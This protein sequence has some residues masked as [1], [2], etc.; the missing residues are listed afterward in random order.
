M[1][2]MRCLL[3]CLVSLNV[4]AIG[5]AHAAALVGHWTFDEG[6]GAVAADSSPNGYDA[7]LFA[8]AGWASGVSSSALSLGPGSDYAQTVTNALINSLSEFSVAFWIKGPAIQTAAGGLFS[9][10]DKAHRSTEALPLYSGW[11]CQGM[12]ASSGN[13]PFV[14]GTGTGFRSITALGVLDDTWHHVAFTVSL[15]P[16]LTLRAYVDGL[17]AG[18][19]VAPETSVAGNLSPLT[20]GISAFHNAREFNG[21]LDDLQIW[22]DTLT[23][24]EIAEI[25]DPSD[26]LPALSLSSLLLL[27]GGLVAAG[28]AVHRS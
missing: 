25:H 27:A 21:A 26:P 12:N 4:A 13:I 17:P 5:R 6:T 14:I 10:L 3:L 11:T 19:V 28:L 16:S 24:A 8:G 15:T 1:M 22:D 2:K 18:S 7:N 9:V 20:M 23:D